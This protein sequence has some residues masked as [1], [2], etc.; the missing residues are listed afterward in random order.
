MVLV[1]CQSGQNTQSYQC[2]TVTCFL[3]LVEISCGEPLFK[4]HAKRLWDGTSHIGSV[5]YY[6]CEE[7]YYT[8]GLKNYS[9]CGENGRWEEIDQWCEGVKFYDHKVS[10]LTA[11]F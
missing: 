5:V 1:S 9:E 3:L 6:Q 7:G 11:E 8:R 2:S 4:P 10:V